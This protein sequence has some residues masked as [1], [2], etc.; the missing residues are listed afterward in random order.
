MSVCNLWWIMRGGQG[1]KTD[2]SSKKFGGLPFQ[3]EQ[4]RRLESVSEI[5][6]GHNF[7]MIWTVKFDLFAG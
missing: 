7:L 6:S 2:I 1:K 4:K 5:Q 3:T